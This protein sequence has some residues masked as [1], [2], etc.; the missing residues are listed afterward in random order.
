[1]KKSIEI[2]VHIFFWVLFTSFVVILSEMYLEAKPDALFGNNFT[3]V[4][5]LEVVM[6]F[7][8]FYIPFLSL[9]WA[10]KRPSNLLIL[11]A[12]LLVLIIFFA[13]P[14]TNV[15]TLQVMSSIVPH[16][17]LIFLA[18]IFRKFSDYSKLVK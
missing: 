13:L 9:P 16:I 11:A 7:I 1:M 3:F 17:F 5:F 8:F 12:I 15:G 2:S 6:G 10:E 18:V 4:V 14:A